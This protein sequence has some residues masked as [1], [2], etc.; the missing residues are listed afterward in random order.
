MHCPQCGQEQVSGEMPFCKNCG[1]SLD[2]VRELLATGN[3]SATLDNQSRKP[4]QSARRQGVRQGVILL[5]ISMVFMPLITLIGKGR[6]EFLPMIFLM[7]GLMRIL[8][9]VIFQEGA[10]RKKKQDS[11]LPY[12]APITTHQLDTVTRSP[13]LP[14]PQSVPVSVFS[15]RRQDTAEMV[16]SPSVTE[17]T[18]KLLNESQDPE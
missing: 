9:A 11:S 12:V 17:H 15:A 16:N 5:F 1:F 4:L 7:A 10:P 6:G 13:A 2:G 14:P 8:Y 3:T 18:T